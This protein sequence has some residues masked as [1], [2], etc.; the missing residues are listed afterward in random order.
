MVDLGNKRY[1]FFVLQ[2]Q[3]NDAGEYNALIAV[4]G[5]KGFYKTDWF[6]GK[7]FNIAEE[8]ADKRNATLELTKK[9]AIKIQLSTM[10]QE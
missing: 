7:D 2:T 6:W 1:C 9:E 10:F 5:E 8:I 4:E 3:V